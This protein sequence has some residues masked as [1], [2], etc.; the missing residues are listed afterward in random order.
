RRHRRSRVGQRRRRQPGLLR[1]QHELRVLTLPIR[2]A[3]GSG[4]SRHRASNTSRSREGSWFTHRPQ[5]LHRRRLLMTRCA[6]VAALPAAPPPLPG[7]PDPPVGPIASTGKTLAQ[8]EPRTPI[9]AATTPGNGG[10]IY[11]IT[12]PGSYYLTDNVTGVSGK[13]GITIS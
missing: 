2:A 9:S 5:S 4:R 7:P 11:R 13:V 8:V 6:L 10:T 3:R 12:Q 1:Q